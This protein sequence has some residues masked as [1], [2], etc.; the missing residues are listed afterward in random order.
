MKT[1]TRK[2]RLERL[3]GAMERAYWRI[4]RAALKRETGAKVRRRA[5]RGKC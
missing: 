2:G 3:R 1:M 5:G 4:V